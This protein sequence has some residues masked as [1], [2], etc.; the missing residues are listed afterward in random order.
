MS[1]TPEGASCP[2]FPASMAAVGR[3]RRLAALRERQRTAN[4]SELKAIQA[5]IDRL[6]SEA[7]Q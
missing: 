6:N 7:A 1:D 2:L 5:E 3:R 4:A